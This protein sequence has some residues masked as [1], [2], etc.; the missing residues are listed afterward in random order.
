MSIFL[1]LAQD[2]SLSPVAPDY[3]IIHYNI[4]ASNCGSCPTTTNH[5]TVTCSDLPTEQNT[6][7]T[8]ALQTVIC[9]NITGILS[10]PINVSL[11]ASNLWEDIVIRS[12]V[13]Y[14]K[15]PLEV[16]FMVRVIFMVSDCFVLIIINSV[17]EVCIYSTFYP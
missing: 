1:I 15:C 11:S 5:T 10:N 3:Q 17:S 9:G 12:T 8:F 6:F 2:D 14:Q 16:I 4:M 7:C 13:S